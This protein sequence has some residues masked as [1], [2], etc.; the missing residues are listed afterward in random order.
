LW[1]AVGRRTGKSIQKHRIHICV[2]LRVLVCVSAACP[3]KLHT[4]AGMVAAWCRKIE[5]PEAQGRGLLTHGASDVKPASDQVRVSTDG[6]AGHIIA[7]PAPP[8][9][10]P[11]NTAASAGA[12]G[13]CTTPAP[14]AAAA[15]ASMAAAE[16]AMAARSALD[17]MEAA[18]GADGS[19]AMA[20]ATAA[21]AADG[22]VAPVASG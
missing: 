11:P 3:A 21:A 7:A 8:R 10:P 15:A 19:A 12:Q 1:V 22:D 16:A 5:I 4:C 17:N 6:H 20:V 2:L 9:R 14:A 13:G 18:S